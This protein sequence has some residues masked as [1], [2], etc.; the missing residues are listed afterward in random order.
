MDET[1]FANI[2]DKVVEGVVIFGSDRK[3]TYCNNAF[4]TMTG[5]D[6]SEMAEALCGVMQGPESDPATI[7]AIDQALAAAKPFSGEVLNYRKSGEPFW[8]RLQVTPV[9]DAGGQLVH[10]IGVSHDVTHTKNTE[11]LAD[12]LERNYRFIFENVKSAITVHGPDAQIRVANQRAVELL[13]L[14]LEDLAGRSPDDQQFRIFREDGSDM[15]LEEYPVMRAIATRESVRDAVLGY[16]RKRDNKCL[17]LVCNASL[18]LAADGD[19][20]EVLLNFSDITRVVESEAEARALRKRFELAARASQDVIFEWDIVTG[21]FW[22]NE[23]HRSIYGYDP[24]SHVN[25]EVFKRTALAR[26]DH[27]IVRDVVLKAIESGQER[28]MVDYDIV[29]AD[30]TTGHVAIRAYIM[31][32]AKGAALRIIGTGTDVGKLTR[33]SEAL[34]KS[35]NRF[36]LIADSANDV[37][38]DHDFE[39]QFTWSSPDWPSKLGIDVEPDDAQDFR[40]LKVVEENDRQRLRSS[41]DQALRSDA[42]SWEM[43]FK[44]KRSDGT[45]IDLALKA[46]IL[47]HPNGRAYRML[48]NMR[49]NTEEKR[50]QEG[51]TRS[52]ALE[53]VG[54]LTGGIAHDFNNL[55]MIILGN[56]EALDLSNLSQEDAETVAMISQ[57]AESAAGLTQRLLTFARQTRLNTTLV[58]VR[59]LVA[60]T[61]MLLRAGLPETIRLTSDVAPDIW[62]VEVDANG[63]EQ[64]LVNLAMNAKDALLRGGEIVISCSNLTVDDPA[65]APASDLSPGRYVVISV[66]DNGEG[67][68]PEVLARAFEPFFT[69]KEIGKGTGLG[70]STVY[71]FAKQSRGAAVIQSNEGHGST[72]ALYLPASDGKVATKKGEGVLECASIAGPARRI[73]VVEDHPQV[74]THVEKTLIRFGY[75]VHTAPDG[76][77]AL[78]SIRN[79]A[80][81]DIIFTDIVMPGGM[82]GQELAAVVANDA[83]NIKLLFTSGYAAGAFEHLGLAEQSN[84]NILQKPYKAAQLRDAIER[85]LGA[86]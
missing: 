71:G 38:W 54:Q 44:A 35:E 30:G 39:T 55:L 34:E 46:S 25:L 24:P 79:G 2:L 63:L 60:D 70:L 64:A 84:L 28:F 77:T 14:E 80:N 50:N 19:V 9:F 20:A 3:I 5:Y 58:D 17:W 86:K 85:A 31:R 47:R 45:L 75:D 51:Y 68:I 67:M 12:K 4:V 37:L 73:L 82:N 43:E 62:N 13:G 29:R 69:T 1:T 10:F 66:A 15:P 59:S 40:W 76:R 81:Y 22:A 42:A 23:A 16:H 6:R 41:L 74:R 72:V 61:M 21:A 26:A 65:M 36:R 83:P 27:R 78:E 53:A 11:I 48:G 33:A 49:N 7:R 8:N 18:V 52:R 32:D 57:A 56:A